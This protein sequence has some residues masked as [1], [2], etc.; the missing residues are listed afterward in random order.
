RRVFCG[1][2][3]AGGGGDRP[4]LPAGQEAGAGASFHP[5]D[6]RPGPPPPDP[7][8]AAGPPPSPRGGAAPP[9]GPEGLACPAAGKS[10]PPR[11][12]PAGQRPLVRVIEGRD[13]LPP[14]AGAPPPFLVTEGLP[15]GAYVVVTSRPGD[16]LDRLLNRLPRGGLALHDL[17]TLDL[18]DM[19]ALLRA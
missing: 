15:E 13:G 4:P 3:R 14:D 7:A 9:G 6:P 11:P 17:G 12:P 19:A 16:R 10:A 18:A 1:A 5:G 8:P 2:R